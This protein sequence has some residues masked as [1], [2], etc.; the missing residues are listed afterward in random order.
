MR[1]DGASL[2]RYE[3]DKTATLLAVSAE[4][5][6]RLARIGVRGFGP[7]I[8]PSSLRLLDCSRTGAG[9]GS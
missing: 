9:T 8:V 7:P 5:D 3:A 4:A 1:V 6:A 2:L